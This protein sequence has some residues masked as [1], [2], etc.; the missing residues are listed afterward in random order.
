MHPGVP[1]VPGR[2]RIS[3]NAAHLHRPVGC[4]SG[5]G[6]AGMGW[7]TAPWRH[8]R[9]LQHTSSQHSHLSTGYLTPQPTVCLSSPMHLQQPTTHTMSPSKYCA[10]LWGNRD[11]V[12]PQQQYCS[13]SMLPAPAQAP[14]AGGQAQA[15]SS[16]EGAL[17]R[18]RAPTHLRLLW[19]CCA[20]S[21]TAAARQPPPTAAVPLLL[22]CQGRCETGPGAAAGQ[23]WPRL[24]GT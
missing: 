11:T 9:H 4:S 17:R 6:A 23:G 7:M 1:A 3:A 16:L 8:P 22:P 24:P 10:L 13:V 15:H 14:V 18:M 21:V 19:P 5:P 20:A 2:I 12:V